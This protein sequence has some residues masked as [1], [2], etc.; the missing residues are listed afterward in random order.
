M[1]RLFTALDPSVPVIHFGTGTSALLELQRDA[2]GAVIGLDWRV[3]LDRAWARLG[4]AVA[5]QGNLDPVVLLASLSEIEC[6]A[7]RILARRRTPRSHFQPRTRNSS[8]NPGRQRPRL[9]RPRPYPL[10]SGVIAPG[11]C[12]DIK[13]NNRV[14]SVEPS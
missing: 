3:E 14:D 12:L 7:R 5:V 13:R 11:D 4:P 6:Q 1:S 10:P 8:R 2:G 9:G